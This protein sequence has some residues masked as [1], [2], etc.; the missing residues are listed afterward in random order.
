MFALFHSQILG[1]DAYEVVWAEYVNVMGSAKPKTHGVARG[2]IK[3]AGLLR[4][5]HHFLEPKYHISIRIYSV[6]YPQFN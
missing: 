1:L 6:L 3:R 5:E 2:T 4:L